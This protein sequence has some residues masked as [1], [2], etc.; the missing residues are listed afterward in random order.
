[1]EPSKRSGIYGRLVES[2]NDF[3]GILAYSVDKRQKNQ[4]IEKYKEQ[5]DSVVQTQLDLFHVLCASDTQLNHFRAEA[6][7]LAEDFA[8]AS[9]EAKL[10][11]YEKEYEQRLQDKLR[12]LKPRFWI[13]V[14]QSVIGGFIF[15]LVL[16]LLVFFSWSL[17]QGPKEL[18]E[19][20]FD[21]KITHAGLVP[22]PTPQ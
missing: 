8:Q 18:I 19:S 17:K 4:I 15:I 10:D 7:K 2:K 11:H 5:G 3:L 1:V 14:W 12:E 13:G 16:G 21:V 9:L 20:I 22:T 6:L